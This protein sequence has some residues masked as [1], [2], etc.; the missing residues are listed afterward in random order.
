MLRVMRGRT[1]RAGFG[2]AAVCPACLYAY[3][4]S[5]TGTANCHCRLSRIGEWSFGPAV[6]RIALRGAAVAMLVSPQASG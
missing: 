2:I 1:C 3:S 4:F 5:I 6:H